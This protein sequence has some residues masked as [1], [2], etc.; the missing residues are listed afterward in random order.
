MW[1]IA[2][3][4]VTAALIKTPKVATN[5]PSGLPIPPHPGAERYDREIGAE[6]ECHRM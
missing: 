6:R 2:D 1:I 4:V 3:V 5:V